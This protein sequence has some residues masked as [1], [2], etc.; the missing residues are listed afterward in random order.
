MRIIAGV[1]KG[2]RL[3]APEGMDT[4]PTTDRV[5]E[6]V[7]NIIQTHLPAR[8]VLDLYAGSA[9]MGLEALSRRSDKCVFVE[10]DRKALSL[11]R[12]NI[13]LAGFDDSAE[14]VAS[15][16]LSYLDSAAPEFDI[17]FMD[18]PY[19]K[20]LISPSLFK[21]SQRGLLSRDGIIVVETEKGGEEP[22]CPDFKTVRQAVY[23][24]VV[25]TV[26]TR[27]DIE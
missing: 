12:H 8:R 17:I 2:L 22:Q 25:I 11:V 6:A 3:K 1:R 18:P 15:D 13:S 24:K 14:V 20:G 21:V 4:R 26:L 10:R 23:G 5:K 16:A 9:A 7:F 19:N 27:G